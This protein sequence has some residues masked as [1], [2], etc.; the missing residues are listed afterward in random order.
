MLSILRKQDE[1]IPAGHMVYEAS[2][3]HGTP[4]ARG[5]FSVKD[6]CCHIISAESED[7]ETLEALVRTA[8]FAAFSSGAH[9]YKGLV[10]A[11]DIASRLASLGFGREGSLETLFSGNCC[12]K[13][14]V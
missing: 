3:G 11:S 6:G 8:F 12:A 7:D 10:G 9:C 4:M 13:S 1:H 2:D 5:E 14:E